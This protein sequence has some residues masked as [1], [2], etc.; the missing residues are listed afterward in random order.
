MSHIAS[1]D[2]DDADLT[3]TTGPSSPGAGSTDALSPTSGTGTAGPD[4]GPGPAAA[5]V[6]ADVDLSGI[7]STGTRPDAG[8][9]PD[10]GPG[11]AVADVDDDGVGRQTALE[12]SGQVALVEPARPLQLTDDTR[13]GLAPRD[14]EL[15]PRERPEGHGLVSHG[16]PDATSGSRPNQG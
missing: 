5:D 9:R 2:H 14:G 6:N 7:G 1:P 13:V 3:G 8:S 11:A 15:L 10:T 12:Q 4:T 16:W